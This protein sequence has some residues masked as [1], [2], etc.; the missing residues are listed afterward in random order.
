[1]G[2]LLKSMM[3]DRSKLVMVVTGDEL[4]GCV[5]VSFLVAERPSNKPVSLRDGSA[6]SIERA[7]TP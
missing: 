2:I 6:Q 3:L 5:F 7:A 4:Q 1:M